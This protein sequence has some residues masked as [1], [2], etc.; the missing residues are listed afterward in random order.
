MTYDELLEGIMN[1]NV[2]AED[3]YEQLF[4]EFRRQ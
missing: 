4:E 2:E 3:V 1:G